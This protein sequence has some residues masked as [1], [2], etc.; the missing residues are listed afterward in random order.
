MELFIKKYIIAGILSTLLGAMLHTGMLFIIPFI[1]GTYIIHKKNIQYWKI[2]WKSCIAIIILASIIFAPI[3]I[4]VYLAIGSSI[5]LI[6]MLS[7]KE[8]RTNAVKQAQHNQQL[9]CPSDKSICPKCGSDKIAIL[10]AKST[11]SIKKAVVGNIIAGGFGTFAGFLG[12]NKHEFMC[13]KCG[14][15]YK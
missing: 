9:K 1:L 13:M 14:H 11:F 3:I 10:N 6:K 5:I 8:F 15:K 4:W 7:N 12:N 2:Y